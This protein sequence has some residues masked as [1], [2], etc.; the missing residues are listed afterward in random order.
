[1]LISCLALK[2]LINPLGW[3]WGGMGVGVRVQS[4]HYMVAKWLHMII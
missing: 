4:D 3:G 1:M 2:G